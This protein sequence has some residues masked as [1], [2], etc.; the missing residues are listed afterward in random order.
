MVVTVQGR[1]YCEYIVYID[2]LRWSLR[3]TLGL[4]SDKS[5]CFNHRDKLIRQ[6]STAFKL[7]IGHG[8]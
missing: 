4:D 5:Q 3:T 6:S 8:T 2:A 7:Q 1:Q